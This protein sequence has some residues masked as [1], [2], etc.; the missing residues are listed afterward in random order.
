MIIA[1]TG[2]VCSGKDAVANI[3]QKKGFTHI[4]LS[5]ILREDLKRQKKEITR[6]NLIV[7]GTNIRK[8]LGPAI[9]AERA[10]AKINENKKY[11]LTSIGRSEEALFLKNKKI[12]IIYVDA[13]DKKRFER[14]RQRKREQDPQTLK[15]FLKLEKLESKGTNFA[16]N[17]D[18]IKKISD[19]ILT[20]NSTLKILEEKIY[21][22]TKYERPDWDSYF[23]EIMETVAKRATCGRGRC[24]A[25]IVKNNNILATG[26]V[27]S[28][29]GMPHCDDVG[30]LMI[31]TK[32]PD[33]IEREHCIR[34]THAE[35]NAIAQAAKHGISLDGSKIYIKMEPCFSCAKQ[36]MSVGIKKIICQK[37]YHAGAETRKM[38]KQAGIKLIVKENKNQEYEK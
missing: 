23:F 2:K 26:Y 32:Y 13:T 19:I 38:L 1:I 28:P 3:L 14:M 20:N 15:E 25:V 37:K 27:G 36:I 29:P 12:K 5:D 18:E 7:A 4:S 9:L 34:T 6:E 35:Q 24:G 22:I 31:T 10:I 11:V 21:K 8:T 17:L 16:R 33:G 30:H